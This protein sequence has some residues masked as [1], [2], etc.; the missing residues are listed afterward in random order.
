MGVPIIFNG[1]LAKLLVQ[2]GL[3][4]QENVRIA[5]GTVNPTVTPVLGE[6]GS[7]YLR[8]GASGGTLY[9]KQD[10]GSTTNWTLFAAGGGGTTDHAALTHLDYASAGH[11]GFVPATLTVNGHALNANVTVTASDV[12]LGNVTNDAQLKAADLDTD[13]TLAANSDAKIPSQKAVKT[14]V[15]TGLATKQNSL[16]FTAVPNTRTVNGHA[17]SA[18][19]T[20]TASDAGAKPAAQVEDIAHGGTGQTTAPL[21]KIALGAQDYFNGIE[22]P[23]AFTMAYRADTRVLT[24]TYGANAAVWVGGV[25]FPKAGSESTAAHAGATGKFFFKYDATGALIVGSTGF[26][27]INEAPL[28]LIYYKHNATPANAKAIAFDERHPSGISSMD[29]A[30]HRYNHNNFGTQMGAGAVISG[31]TLGTQGASA[32]SYA[33]GSSTLS[34]E[35]LI[36]TA[37]ALADG[38]PYPIFWGDSAAAATWD[39]DLTSVTGILDDGTDIVY[40]SLAAGTK[41]ALTGTQRAIYWPIAL[42]FYATIQGS[43]QTA[44][45]PGYAVIM[46]QNVYATL[47]AAQ[48]DAPT[49]LIGLS[50]LTE[51]G[52]VFARMIYQRSAG[53]TP[54]HAQ[55]DVDPTYYRGNVVSLAAGAFTPTDH[56]SLSNRSA[57]GAHPASSVANTPAGNIA[58]T[59]VQSALNELD[60]EKVPTTTTVNGHALSANVSVTASDVG[61]KPTAQVEDIAHGGTGQSTK[62]AAMDALSPLSTKGDTLVYSTTNTKQAVPVDYGSLVPDSTQATGW[63]SATRNGAL[64]GNTNVKNYIDN[65]D[66]ENNAVNGWSLFHTTLTGV[67]PTG[68]IVAGAS[69][70][71]ALAVTATPLA[72]AYSLS[73]TSSGAVTAGHGF[74]TQTLSIDPADQG[75]IIAFQFNYKAISGTMNFSGTSSNTWAVYIYDDANSAW[76]QP[77]GV[78]NLVQSSGVGIATGTFQTAANTTTLQLAVVCVNATGGAVSVT[79]D[80]FKLGPQTVQKGPAMSDWVAYTPT[81]TGFGT[82]SANTGFYR[83]I[84]D[85]IEVSGSLVVGTPTAVVAQI[86]LPSGLVIDTAKMAAAQTNSLGIAVRTAGSGTLAG[87]GN[88]PFVVTDYIGTSTTSVVIAT[89]TG[90]T[91]Y[92]LAVGNVIAGSGNVITYN[93]RVSISGFSSSSVTSQDTDTRVV[94]ATYWRSSSASVTANNQ[95]N[96]D[97]KSDDTHAAVT[98]GASWKFT[99]PVVGFYQVDVFNNATSG[100]Y[101]QAYKNGSVLSVIGY[102]TSDGI[103]Q[104]SSLIYLLAGDTLDIRPSATGTVNGNASFSNN[105]ASKISIF[106]LSGPAV[107]AASEKVFSQYTG[108]GGTALTANTTNIDFS[109]KVVDSHAAW[110]GTVF[111]APRPGWYDVKGSVK[112]TTTSNPIMYAYVNTVQKLGLNG[113]VGSNTS[114]FSF[115]GGIYLNAGD[116]LSVRSDTSLTLSNSATQDWIAITSQG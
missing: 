1:R 54:S 16:G 78:Y 50:N 109:T 103:A 14:Y 53:S 39:W 26:D 46:G 41:V 20:V 8:Y 19:V 24:V 101:I 83:R 6:Q 64:R 71:S 45:S 31:Y 66:F 72:G 94:A 69:S 2:D 86:A 81:I 84:G 87:S 25:K 29:A 27:L 36:H 89:G 68:S 98:T 11:T 4:F 79:F 42:P 85:S 62:A 95:I 107:I 38:G 111:T 40:N 43:T 7:L 80:D 57:T 59:D 74:L 37:V 10:A 70:L 82:V 99:A 104:C 49:S 92:T 48:A 73:V 33:V 35:D 61:A 22:V 110:N 15:D 47:A 116:A 5:V 55:I 113:S 13:G 102:T 18:D 63:R 3:K 77:A 108:N 65:P 21:A 30:A 9:Q 106:R 115:S 12:G 52:V 34:D 60:T 56:Q 76:I 93:F 44:K 67:I 91:A 32:L 28:L 90:A 97:S 114:I 58:S 88:G 96:Y 51:E 105:Q 112:F 75:K 23:S 17:L 100:Q